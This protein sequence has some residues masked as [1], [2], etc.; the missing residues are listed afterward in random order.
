MF[1]YEL[2][3]F[4]KKKLKN[5]N[6]FVVPCDQLPST[7]SL[8]AG[9]IVNLSPSIHPGSHWI[10]IFIDENGNAVYFC[11]FG[12][13]TTVKSILNFLKLKCKTVRYNSV[14]LQRVSSPFCGQYAAVF[15]FNSFKGVSLDT[16]LRYFSPN[17]SHNDNLIIKMY[18]RL[19][20]YLH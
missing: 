12:R 11:S 6:I 4:L 1:L 5:E 3:E 17:L 8:P 13:K 10:A 20:K 9:L 18:S 15:L 2:L 19:D 7:F 16:F 14:Q